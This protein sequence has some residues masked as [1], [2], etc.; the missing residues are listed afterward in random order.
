MAKKVIKLTEAQLKS[1]VERVISEQ[2]APAP[3][4]APGQEL[5]KSK[6]GRTQARQYRFDMISERDRN[7]FVE[8]LTNSVKQAPLYISKY[9]NAIVR[10]KDLGLKEVNTPG[11]FKNTGDEGTL[12]HTFTL[13]LYFFDTPKNSSDKGSA[14]WYD[15]V[16]YI[17]AANPKATAQDILNNVGGMIKYLKFSFGGQ[18]QSSVADQYVALRQIL[19]AK[20]AV[21]LIARITGMNEY[22]VSTWLE[23]TLYNDSDETEPDLYGQTG[24]DKY[25]AYYDE[26]RKI[27]ALTDK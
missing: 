17:G 13:R 15:V 1:V 6:D 14:V 7:A 21:L 24:S 2:A 19:P 10:L 26:I 18:Q 22:Y 5:I 12:T 8:G 23:N 20:N 3:K 27:Y 25:K 16:Y 4:L 11:Y 9:L